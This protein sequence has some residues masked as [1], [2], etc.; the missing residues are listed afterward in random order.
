MHSPSHPFLTDTH[1]HLDFEQFA[2]DR[3]EVIENALATGIEFILIPAVELSQAP[4][5]QALCRAYAPIYAAFGVHPNSV[6]NF[7]S[8][9][10]NTLQQLAVQPKVVA[11]GEIGLDYYWQKVPAH[12]QKSA[13]WQQL[14]LADSLNLPVVIHCRNAFAD[15]YEIVQQWVLQRK[16][17]CP[18]GVFHSFSGDWDQAQQVLDLGFYLGVTGPVTFGK[19]D[20]LRR[21]AIR[22]PL[23]RLL[24]ET[25]APYLTPAPLRGKRNEPAYVRFTAER[26]ATERNMELNSFL[27]TTFKNACQ[28]FGIKDHAL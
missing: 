26:I 27:L 28:L 23:E 14:E 15:V 24:I 7:T 10:L 8:Q 13:F 6:I 21:V 20:E 11:I 9:E 25:D 22:T 19:S 5:I 4:A 18:P 1:C 16:S 12:Q 3:A 2:E 17:T